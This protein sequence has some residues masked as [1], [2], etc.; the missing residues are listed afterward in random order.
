[1][2]AD[3]AKRE[4]SCTPK[5]FDALLRDENG[6]LRLPADDYNEVISGLLIGSK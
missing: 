6:S 3:V 4:T 2:S 5:E 1:M